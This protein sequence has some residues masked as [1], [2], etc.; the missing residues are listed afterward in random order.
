MVSGAV[1]PLTCMSGCMS[2]TCSVICSRRSTPCRGQGRDLGKGT[3]GVALMASTKRRA[4]ERPLTSFAPQCVQPFQSSHASVQV[5]RQATPAG[6]RQ[7]RA[8]LLSSV[9][10]IRACKGTSRFAQ[11]GAIRRVL[12]QRMF[13]QISRVR[14]HTLPRIASQTAT[15]R[16]SA[17]VNSSSGFCVPPQPAPNG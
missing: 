8:K 12:H 15:R 1:Y 6:S 17:D 4:R 13:E 14:R 10:A 5:T 7:C 9:S 2:A 3:C 11:E 16:S